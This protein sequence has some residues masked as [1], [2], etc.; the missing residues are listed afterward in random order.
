LKIQTVWLRIKAL[1]L[2]ED[3]LRDLGALDYIRI[4]FRAKAHKHSKEH[5]I[6]FF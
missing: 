5:F 1:K 4:D 2:R 3:F 6:D